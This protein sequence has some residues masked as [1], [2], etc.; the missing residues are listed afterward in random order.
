V[1]LTPAS[2]DREVDHPEDGSEKWI[3][4]QTD[5]RRDF[6]ATLMLF[7]GCSTWPATERPVPT[8]AKTSP[9]ARSICGRCRVVRLG[10]RLEP[11]LQEVRGRGGPRGKTVTSR[12]L[13]LTGPEKCVGYQAEKCRILEILQST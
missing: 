3:E 1:R 12:P 11:V 10:S 13:T 5:P 4:R 6:L 8:Q 7:Y 2:S 9:E